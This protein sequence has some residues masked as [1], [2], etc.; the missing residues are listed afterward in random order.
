MQVNFGDTSHLPLLVSL[1]SLAIGLYFRGTTLWVMVATVLCFLLVFD[2]DSI[3]TLVVYGFTALLV[4]AGYQRIK[5]GLRKT[6]LDGADESENPQFDLVIDGN[7]LLGT[8]EWEFEPLKRFIVE[9]QSDKFKVHIFFDHSIYRLLKTNKL[10]EPTETVPMTLCRIME[11]NRS[12]LT[13]S[14]KGHKADALLIRYADRNKNTVLS[15][16]KFNKLS[17]DRFYLKAAE[18]LTKKGLIKRVG[19]IEGKLTIM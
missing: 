3:I 2:R 14:K 5:F 10:M 13:V 4:I 9:L 16:D 11:M 7:N 18:R 1:I 15:N 8:V 6:Q 17:D 12:N 19:L